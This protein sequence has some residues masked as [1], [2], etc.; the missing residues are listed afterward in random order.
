MSQLVVAGLCWVQQIA[1]LPVFDLLMATVGRNYSPWRLYFGTSCTQCLNIKIVCKG[2]STLAWPL[3]PGR[4]HLKLWRN[5][6]FPQKSSRSEMCLL[7]KKE[8]RD[9]V[10]EE[11]LVPRCSR[12]S[13]SLAADRTFILIVT[14]VCMAGFDWWECVEV[15]AKAGFVY[16]GDGGA[17]WAHIS[18]LVIKKGPCWDGSFWW[19]QTVDSPANG[20]QSVMLRLAGLACQRNSRF[21]KSL[22]V[23]V[24]HEDCIRDRLKVRTSAIMGLIMQ[25][26]SLSWSKISNQS[27]NDAESHFDLSRCVEAIAKHNATRGI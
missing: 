1:Q 21:Q 7:K 6:D 5:F 13:D 9:W 14:A 16:I 4:K 22:Q 12:C 2:S 17:G 20:S 10:R 24:R 11:R 8:T 25:R 23:E 3:F 19:I 18:G 15:G 26:Y 27:F